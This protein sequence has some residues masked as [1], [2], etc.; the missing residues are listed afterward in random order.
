MAVL[1]TAWKCLW[2]FLLTGWYGAGEWCI[3]LPLISGFGK[4]PR[5]KLWIFISKNNRVRVR[6]GW[7]NDAAVHCLPPAL[8]AS[9]GQWREK[10]SVS[11]TVPGHLSTAGA[12]HTSIS[13]ADHLLWCTFIQTYHKYK[14]YHHLLATVKLEI[15]WRTGNPPEIHNLPAKGGFFWAV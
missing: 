9:T 12:A 6:S 7:R 2:S 8:C 1:N 15:L 5:G 3:I 11:G 4:N 13:M 10:Q 14:F